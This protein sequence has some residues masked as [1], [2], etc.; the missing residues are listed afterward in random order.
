MLT[1]QASKYE[2]KEENKEDKQASEKNSDLD[3]KQVDKI[4]K[5]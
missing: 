3:Q 5:Q 4:K 1:E 2:A